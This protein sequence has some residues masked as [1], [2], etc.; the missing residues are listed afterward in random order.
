MKSN[1]SPSKIEATG[2]SSHGPEGSAN[3]PSTPP[4]ASTPSEIRISLVKLY[5]GTID[6]SV[7]STEGGWNVLVIPS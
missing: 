5:L 4:C 1:P 7:I 3:Q 6:S 2:K